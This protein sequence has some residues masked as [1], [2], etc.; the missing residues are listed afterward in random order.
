MKLELDFS[1]NLRENAALFYERSKRAKEKLRS[2]LEAEKKLEAELSS[3]KKVVVEKKQLRKKEK[4][5]REWFEKF[6]WFKTTGGLVCIAGR[7]AKQND[8]LFAKYMRE[9]DLFFH[10]DIQGAAF[11][12]LKEGVEA[13]SEDKLQAAQFAACNSSAWKRG[14]ATVDVY[15]CRKEQLSK[16]SQGE[17]VGKGGFA[18]KGQREWFKNTE[19]QLA[20]GVQNEKVV[21]VPKLALRSF[22]AGFEP[23]VDEPAGEERKAQKVLVVPKLCAPKSFV[24]VSPAEKKENI[25]KISF[26]LKLSP[27]QKEALMQLLP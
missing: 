2:L 22:S 23:G 20:V 3:L 9:G 5:S 4:V 10:A 19:L 25:A 1:K 13:S 7:D 6:R 14:F 11:T 24:E 18:M 16:Y 12:L 8:L 27:E 21:V 15:S 26:A 17:F